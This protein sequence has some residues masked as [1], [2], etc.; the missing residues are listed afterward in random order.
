VWW[1]AA[2]RT[3]ERHFITKLVRKAGGAPDVRSGSSLSMG[4]FARPFPHEAAQVAESLEISDD[5]Q[6][7]LTNEHAIVG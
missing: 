5:F 4:V 6:M 7:T 2:V 3:E 1:T